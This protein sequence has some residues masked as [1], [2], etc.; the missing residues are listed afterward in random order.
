[1]G[2]NY[3]GIEKNLIAAV[4]QVDDDTPREYPNKVLT[5][6][7]DSMWL[8]LHN[9]RAESDPVTLGNQGEDE[10]PGFLQID[11]NVPKNGGTGEVLAK[12]DDFVGFFTA[13]K[14]LSY[15]AQN[16][17]VLSSSLSSGRYVGGYYRISVTVNYYSRIQRNI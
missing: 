16:V 2:S 9:K 4:R 5:T 10:Y 13:G 6:K 14:L 15:N 8:S 7:P 17:K 3:L 11:I 12:A 1:M